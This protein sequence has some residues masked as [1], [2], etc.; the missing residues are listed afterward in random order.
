MSERLNNRKND[1]L[2]EISFIKDYTKHALS[3]VLVQFGD[4]KVIVTASVDEKA[5]KWME[6]DDPKTD[7]QKPSFLRGL[8]KNDRTYSYNRCRC[9]SG[10]WRNKMCQHLR[11]ISCA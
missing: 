2:R 3:S 10:R 7:R 11:G 8:G 1:E 5:P 6:K 4:T 9:N